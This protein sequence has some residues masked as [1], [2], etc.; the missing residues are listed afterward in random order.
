MWLP[1]MNFLKNCALLTMALFY[2]VIFFIDNSYATNYYVL[3]FDIKSPNGNG[4][5]DSP[6][7]KENH[8][9]AWNGLTNINW[10]VIKPGDNILLKKN[11]VYF[12]QI[13]IKKNGKKNKPICFSAF[14]MGAKPIISGGK[15]LSQN[16]FDWQFHSAKQSWKCNRFADRT[17]CNQILNT[18]VINGIPLTRSF[19]SDFTKFYG[20]FS[21]ASFNKKIIQDD[22]PWNHDIFVGVLPFNVL[23]DQKNH[24]EFKDIEF[25]LANGWSIPQRGSIHIINGSNNIHFYNCNITYGAFSGFWVVNS[26]DIRI[27]KC[28]I[29]GNYCTGLYFRAGSSY[30]TIKDCRIYENGKY[31]SPNNHT[32]TGALLLGSSGTGTGHIIEG[33][34]IFNNGRETITDRID[35]LNPNGLIYWEK[36]KGN[37]WFKNLSPL[38]RWA[39]TSRSKGVHH[40]GINNIPQKKATSRENCTSEFP[41]FWDQKNETIYFYSPT[42][43]NGIDSRLEI[44]WKNGPD[45]AIS[46]WGITDST[47]QN[48]TIRDNF[49]CGI[50]AVYKTTK[51]ITIVNN[52]INNNLR[53]KSLLHSGNRYGLCISGQGGHI[54]LNNTITNNGNSN[55]R[56]NPKFAG[57]SISSSSISPVNNIRI[58]NNKILNNEGYQLSWYRYLTGKVFQN[59]YCDYN[60][61]SGKNLFFYLGNSY[62]YIKDYSEISHQDKH[63][64]RVK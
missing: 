61:F 64:V 58:E 6:A 26:H 37:I 55:T 51:N 50:G 35:C 49:S 15:Q 21:H 56:K 20:Q 63:S 12:G 44:A 41:W 28:D 52:I 17:P 16:P 19:S 22:K 47:I 39:G 36:Y 32:D 48:N 60:M 29:L 34:I 25:T 18:A 9:G 5:N 27:E 33:N 53:N 3:P 62:D 45:P 43:P 54:V 14:G 46:L 42:D 38:K 59:A 24:I 7:P 30:A 2:L 8:D 23:I 31:L 57:L 1:P 10:Q 13:T 11:S 40:L 4:L